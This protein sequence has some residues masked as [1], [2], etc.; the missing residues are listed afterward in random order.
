MDEDFKTSVKNEIF[1]HGQLKH[2]RII[3]FIESFEDEKY[4]YMI[5][6]LCINGSL[7][8]LQK[9]RKIVSPNEC[10]YF[11]SQILEGV[12]YIHAKEIIHRD[13]KSEN[14]MFNERMQLKIGDFGLSVHKN[15]TRLQ[16]TSICGTKFYIA[17]E[18]VNHEGFVQRSDIWAIGVITYELLFGSTPFDGDNTYQIYRRIMQAEYM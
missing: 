3:E 14:I 15:D 5:Q 2:E 16:S 8:D 10:R 11:I 17:P 6:F 1:I 13:L 12:K 4:V 7:Y 18:V 9:H